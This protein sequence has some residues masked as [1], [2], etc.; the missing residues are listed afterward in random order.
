MISRQMVKRI[1]AGRITSRRWVGVASAKTFLKGRVTGGSSGLTTLVSYQRLL[2]LSW[3]RRAVD[4]VPSSPTASWALNNNNICLLVV[5]QSRLRNVMRSR[6]TIG[7]SQMSRSILITQKRNWKIRMRS[8]NAR[9]SRCPSCQSRLRLW[10]KRL[11]K[12]NPLE[13]I[14]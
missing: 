14:R 4:I 13:L 2:A 1:R 7:L 5:I 9:N 3:K 6:T 8:L 12:L 10:K 11:K